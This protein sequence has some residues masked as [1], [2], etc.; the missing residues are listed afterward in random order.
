MP[1]LSFQL[2]LPFENTL[3]ALKTYLESYNN[4]LH[5]KI[6]EGLMVKSL[7]STSQYSE[8]YNA[9]VD[10]HLLT[11]SQQIALQQLAFFLGVKEYNQQNFKDAI[12]YFTVANRYPI[13]DDYSYLTNYLVS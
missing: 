7:Q 12:S 11:N 2:E 4:P 3:A 6:I 13:N 8:A 9:L 1:K 10:I 5:K